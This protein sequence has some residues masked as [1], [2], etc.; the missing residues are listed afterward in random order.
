MP[1][2]TVSVYPRYKRYE[3]LNRKS[4]VNI[5]SN[6]TGPSR[7]VER[8]GIIVIV[9]VMKRAHSSFPIFQAAHVDGLGSM[10]HQALDLFFS[11]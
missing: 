9:V 5:I 3:Y 1:P 11:L 6:T 7:T 8:R 4:H 10:E 2:P